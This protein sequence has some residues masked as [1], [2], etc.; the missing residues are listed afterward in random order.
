M[1]KPKKNQKE[2]PN[3]LQ[4][5]D[6]FQTPFY[7]TDLIIPFLPNGIIW[8]CAAGNGYIRKRLADFNRVVEFTDL[9]YEPS[10]NYLSDVPLF[11]FDLIVTNPPFSLKKRF[12]DKC[13][14]YKKPFALLIPVDFCGWILRGMMDYNLQWI[15]PTRRIDFI[16]PTGKEGKNSTAQYHSGWL[17]YG[18]E[19]KKDITV[20]ELT[21]K[22]KENIGSVV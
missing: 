21:N 8:E 5:R 18:F 6:F 15:I 19:L 3:T 22:Q 12:F 9:R 17:T 13:I 11:D 4:E 14:E 16:T 10:F 20:V 7:A 1:N 2:T